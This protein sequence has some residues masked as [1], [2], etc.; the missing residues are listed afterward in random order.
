VIGKTLITSTMEKE[1]IGM[2]QKDLAR[3]RVIKNLIAKL[4]NGTDAAKQLSLSVRQVKRL[5]ARV[6][7][8]GAKGIPHRSRNKE[9]QPSHRSGITADCQGF[10]RG[11][12]PGLWS[13]IRS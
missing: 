10:D 11:Q 8:D 1:I 9:G 6:I 3:Y 13:D 12:I 5:K 7:V 2:T 4:I